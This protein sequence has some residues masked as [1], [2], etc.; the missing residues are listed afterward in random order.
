MAAVQLGIKL[1]LTCSAFP[2]ST[3]VKKSVFLL[4][5]LKNVSSNC[6]C[7]EG[8]SWEL[9]STTTTHFKH[10]SNGAH[11]DQFSA[12]KRRSTILSKPSGP[13]PKCSNNIRI[14]TFSS[15][16]V[17]LL[18]GTILT[19]TTLVATYCGWN[20]EEGLQLGKVAWIQSSANAMVVSLFD[21][22][23]NRSI[24]PAEANFYR[25]EC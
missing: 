1:H 12:W 21:F 22:V 6:T 15:Q 24:G 10:I 8:G 19:D 9:F 25:S 16:L 4:R 23:D 18:V 7:R 20:Y 2:F 11:T 13:L 14:N 5:K 17:V 3:P